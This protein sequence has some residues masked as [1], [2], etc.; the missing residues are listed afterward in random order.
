MIRF[1]GRILCSKIEKELRQPG[2]YGYGIAMEF[3]HLPLSR[4]TM[5][6]GLI[7]LIQPVPF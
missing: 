2:F 3:N 1:F 5:G 7:G 4:T 6:T